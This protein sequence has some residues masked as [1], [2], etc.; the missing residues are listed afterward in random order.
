MRLLNQRVA[1]VEGILLEPQHFQ[2]LERYV[3]H[4]I[5]ARA[6]RLVPN[7]W[8]LVCL[9]IDELVDDGPYTLAHSPLFVY[10]PD[11]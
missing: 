9:A 4:T 6:R 8:G 2:Q 10:S 11:G 7:G 3:E 5:H 1:W